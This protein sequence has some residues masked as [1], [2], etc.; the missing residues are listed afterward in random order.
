M[1]GNRFAINGLNFTV[2]LFLN[3][4]ASLSAICFCMAAFCNAQAIPQQTGK[5]GYLVSDGNSFS[6]G[7]ITTGPSGA[8]DC[9][10][11]AG[12]CDI[13]TALV[14]LKVT[15]NTWSG[16]NDFGNAAFLRLL[17][18]AGTPSKGCVLP[19]D[20]GKVYVRNDA[21]APN[22]SLYICDQNAPGAYSWELAQPTGNAP[23]PSAKSAISNVAPASSVQPL[24]ASAI[25]AQNSQ[26]P[27]SFTGNGS[28]TIS[29]TGTTKADDCAKWDAQ[30]N[31]IDSGAPCGSGAAGGAA[32]GGMPVY[33]AKGVPLRG[34]IVT[35]RSSFG[36]KYQTTVTFS[37]SAAF[38]SATSYVCTGS[39][40]SGATAPIGVEQ[41]SGAKI[42]FYST[43]GKGTNEF[44]YI[45]VG[46]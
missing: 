12:V 20:N 14:P 1:I 40:I 33:S 43:T 41:K 42:T 35:G 24:N 8:L 28:K 46:N 26:A 16:A 45:C 25:P 9:V 27:L 23:V 29:S 21:K 22:S 7:N 18:G 3:E 38:T 6:W 15:A 36:G 32:I 10:S 17:S 19:T 5:P 2:K 34:H 44:S 37:G 31:I 30:G 13:V 39:D 11:L 4:I